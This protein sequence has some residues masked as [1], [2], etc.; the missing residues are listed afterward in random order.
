MYT[1]ILKLPRR[2]HPNPNPNPNP[3]PIPNPTPDP[4]PDPS[5]ELPRRKPLPC[6]I[7]LDGGAAQPLRD[8]FL[9]GCFVNKYTGTEHRITPFAQLDD[10]ELATR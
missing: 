8:L 1:E 10:G 6:K 9:F 7:A 2:T 5:P 4:N 3:H